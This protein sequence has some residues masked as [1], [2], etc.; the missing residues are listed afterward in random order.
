MFNEGSGWKSIYSVIVVGCGSSG[1]G[2]CEVM[3]NLDGWSLWTGVIHFYPRLDSFY[4]L[5]NILYPTMKK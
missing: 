3:F 1:K 5:C 4:F 2:R